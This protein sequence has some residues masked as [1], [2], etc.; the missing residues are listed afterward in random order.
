MFLQAVVDGTP[1]PAV[2]EAYPGILHE[3]FMHGRAEGIASWREH[4]TSIEPSILLA[5][6][7][8]RSPARDY[9][10]VGS[11]QLGC[12]LAILDPRVVSESAQPRAWVGI[13]RSRGAAPRDDRP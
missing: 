3:G 11:M 2:D 9:L 5:G 13:R 10:L 7:V 1:H 8:L 6:Q 4:G 12:L